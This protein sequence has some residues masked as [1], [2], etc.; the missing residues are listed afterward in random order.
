MIKYHETKSGEIFFFED[1]ETCEKDYQSQTDTWFY[2]VRL[3]SGT[4]IYMLDE[5]WNDF[6]KTLKS[7][8]KK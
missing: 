5:E 8:A 6:K 2:F 3:K 7:I 1:V 4:K